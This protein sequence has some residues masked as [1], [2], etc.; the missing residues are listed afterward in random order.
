METNGEL[1]P[2]RVAWL[3]EGEAHTR[4]LLQVLEQIGGYLTPR[5]MEILR[6]ARCWMESK[7]T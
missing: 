3:A 6:S 2:I 7:P 5:E 1:D 4:N